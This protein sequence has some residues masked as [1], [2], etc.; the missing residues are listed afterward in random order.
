M[1]SNIKWRLTQEVQLPIPTL[2]SPTLLARHRIKP[3]TV[4]GLSPSDLAVLILKIRAVKI[5][6]VKILGTGVAL[7]IDDGSVAKVILKQTDP[8]VD[9]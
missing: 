5:F 2:P 6:V 9:F 4:L 3:P 8:R 1:G 7:E